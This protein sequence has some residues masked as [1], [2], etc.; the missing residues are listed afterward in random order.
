M[1]ISLQDLAA[2]IKTVA[3]HIGRDVSDAVIDRVVKNTTM[4]AMRE[5]YKNAMEARKQ[6]IQKVEPTSLFMYLHKG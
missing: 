4:D 1:F 6:E 3:K 5:N 2:V